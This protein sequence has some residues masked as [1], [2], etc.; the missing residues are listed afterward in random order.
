MAKCTSVFLSDQHIC[1]E[2]FLLSVSLTES[3]YSGE[4]E[5]L[6]SSQKRHSSLAL[7]TASDSLNN[8]L[9][10]TPLL[11]TQNMI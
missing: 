5:G 3:L 11:F 2:T 4:Y 1:L 10:E 8:M 9:S 7:N 6:V